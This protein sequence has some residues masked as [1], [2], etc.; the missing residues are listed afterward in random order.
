MPQEDQKAWDELV[1]LANFNLDFTRTN[2]LDT[3]A[4]RLF[5][6]GPGSYANGAPIRM[7]VLGSSSLGHL[8]PAIRVGGL[9]RG[10][11]IE[12]FEGDYGQYLQDLINT[13]SALHN[14]SPTVVLFALDAVHVTRALS[15]RMTRVEADASLD[16]VT[17]NIEQCWTLAQKHFGC[18]IVQQT[19]LPVLDTV[20]GQNE[21]RLPG[22]PAAA[23]AHINRRLEV[24]AETAGVDL[25]RIDTALSQSGRDGW[26]NPAFWHHAKQEVVSLAAPM[27]GELAARLLAAQRGRSFKCLVL[28]LDNTL[29]GGVIGDD[30]LE[31]IILGQGTAQG[32]GFIAVQRYA[33]ALSERGIILAICSKNDEA[34]ALLPFDRHPEMI[35]RRTDIAAYRANWEDK[36]TNIRAIANELNIGLDSLVFLDDNPFERALVRREL[37]M[38]A[39]PEVPEDPALIPALLATAGYFEATKLSS[40]DLVRSDQYQANRARQAVLSSATDISSYLRDLEMRLVWGRFD[41]V[42]LGRIVQLINKTNQFN[43]TTRRY[44]EKEIAEVIQ[45]SNALGLHFRLLDRFGDNGMIAVVIGRKVTNEDMLIDTWLMS[46]RV[47]GRAV[48]RATLN[49]LAAQ[50]K[51]LGVRNLIG[52]YHPT[53]K[54]QMVRGHYETIGFVCEKSAEGGSEYFLSLD[55]YRPQSVDIAVLEG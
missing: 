53:A 33:K 9:R 54:N 27:Y 55:N 45:E 7:A 49:V 19:I 44:T 38:V 20:M 23:I 40:D 29:W 36:A 26:Y 28:D 37:P 10:L 50:A 8:M 34:N 12:T 5:P 16:R 1:S 48:E 24:S 11:W 4:R 15:L 18:I 31:G 2:A 30:G 17:A 47:L 6:R 3:T 32:E 13:S 35:L 46:C 51:T 21:H 22:S 43:L 25:L 14:F 41:Q 52:Q 42:N 39:V